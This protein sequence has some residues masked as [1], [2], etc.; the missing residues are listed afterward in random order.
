MEERSASFAKTVLDRSERTVR[1]HAASAYRK[2]GLAVRAGPSAFFLEHLLLPTDHN[3]EQ[4]RQG[5]RESEVQ[6]EDAKIAR[7]GGHPKAREH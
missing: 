5:A 1:R 4:E 7:S 3:G 2:S 6:I